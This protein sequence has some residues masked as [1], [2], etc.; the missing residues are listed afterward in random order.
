METAS[1]HNLEQGFNVDDA[2]VEGDDDDMSQDFTSAV[3]RAELARSLSQHETTTNELGNN[4]ASTSKSVGDSNTSVSTIDIY[5]PDHLS[6]LPLPAK[7]LK[8]SPY[9]SS[10][11]SYDSDPPSPSSPRFSQISLSD[12][13]TQESQEAADPAVLEYPSVHIEVSEGVESRVEVIEVANQVEWLALSRSSSSASHATEP[14]RPESLR[15]HS[16]QSSAPSSASSYV[17]NTPPLATASSHSITSLSTPDHQKL[18]VAIKHR[19][20]RSAG[21]NILDKVYSKTRPTF[22]PPKT[23]DEDRK[24]LAVWEH[25]MKESRAVGKFE[26]ADSSGLR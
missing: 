13:L 26:V 22:L 9:Q 18:D 23:A 7:D 3:I 25:M 6:S 12:D 10:D 14:L 1:S 5:G 15:T 17:V 20:T 16:P 4:G 8:K 21:P 19:P 2:F 11:L 24:H